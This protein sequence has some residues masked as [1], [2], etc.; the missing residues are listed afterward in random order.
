[1][2]RP[3]TTEPHAGY[4]N[5]EVSYERGD[6]DARSVVRFGVGFALLV[7]L[8]AVLMWGMYRV[9]ERRLAP[10]RKTDLPAAAV[11]QQQGLPPIPLEAIE[12]VDKGQ[13]RLFPPR[14]AEDARPRQ[15]RLGGGDA[16]RG[17]LPIEEAMEQY[18]AEQARR[19]PRRGGK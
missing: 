5:P 7:A 9:V 16:G 6:I 17:V 13:A 19:K 18:A 3:R 2:A 15:A 10:S 12:D 14:A 4:T 1:M 8:S 11:D